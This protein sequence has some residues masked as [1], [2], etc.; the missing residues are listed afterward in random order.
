[1]GVREAHCSLVN[2]NV[3]TRVPVA[4]CCLVQL[5]LKHESILQYSLDEIGSASA[6]ELL[7]NFFGLGVF[8][9]DVF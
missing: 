7:Q 3:V 6:V 4:C 5:T 1:M 9:L 8:F 2:L